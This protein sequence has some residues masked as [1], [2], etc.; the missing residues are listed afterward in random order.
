M[1][2]TT[3]DDIRSTKW[4]QI[5]ADGRR[6]TTNDDGPSRCPAPKRGLSMR[7]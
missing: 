5:G 2:M 7:W 4:R 1:P 3:D 6:K